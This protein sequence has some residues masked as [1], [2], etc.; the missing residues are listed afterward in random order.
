[1]FP[2][3]FPSIFNSYSVPGT[4][5]SFWDAQ[6]KNNMPRCYSG[7]RREVRAG[8]RDQRVVGRLSELYKREEY[9]KW[10]R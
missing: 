2:S 9:G 8:E 7:G 3:F 6:K 5:L 4:V 1:M 10:C